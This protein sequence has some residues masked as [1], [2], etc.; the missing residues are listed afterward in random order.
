MHKHT[1]KCLNI[2]SII[3]HLATICVLLRT[4]H[5]EREED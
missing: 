4:L 5:H 2:I 1:S 3:L